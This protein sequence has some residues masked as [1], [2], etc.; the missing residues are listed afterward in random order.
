LPRQAGHDGSTRFVEGSGGFLIPLR[1]RPQT[2]PSMEAGRL[3][4][5]PEQ[6]TPSSRASGS[7]LAPQAGRP[8]RVLSRLERCPICQFELGTTSIEAHWE[9]EHC[10]PITFNPSPVTRRRSV[11]VRTSRQGGAK[12]TQPIRVR[13]GVC[14][15]MIRKELLRD[16]LTR[17]HDLGPWPAGSVSEVGSSRPHTDPV[18]VKRRFKSFAELRAFHDQLDPKP[19]LSRPRVEAARPGEQAVRRRRLTPCPRCGVQ[20]REDRLV[21]HRDRCV[22]AGRPKRRRPA[23][24]ERSSNCVLTGLHKKQ[25]RDQRQA[26]QA[27]IDETIG[28]RDPRDAT[29]G[30]GQLCR[31]PNGRFGSH[32]L[33][34]AYGDESDA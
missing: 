19:R 34:D 26:E 5:R 6:P 17:A 30:L 29:R 23:D 11:P 24:P 2:S 15:A 12:K 20:V 32:P 7:E 31:E 18:E 9:A 3:T 33:H 21:R 8:A 27:R 1:P 22:P 25:A 16:H 28:V 10:R 4:R 13:C 14:D